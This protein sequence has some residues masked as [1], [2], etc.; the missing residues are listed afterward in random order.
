MSKS[1]AFSSQ[2]MTILSDRNFLLTKKVAL[3]KIMRL[4]GNLAQDLQQ[5]PIHQNFQ[6]PKGTDTKRGK[7]SKGENYKGLPYMVLDFPKLFN[8]KNIFTY[9]SMFWWGNSFSFTLHIG[10]DYALQY[11]ENILKN[12]KTLQQSEVF[13]CVN[14]TPW[15]YDFEAENYCNIADLDSIHVEEYI[16]ANG[17]I[18]LSRSLPLQDWERVTCYGSSTYQ[19][20]FNSLF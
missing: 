13:F 19:L 7:I 14:N 9:R 18:K 10:G 16:A 4:L 12:L 15:E 20:F 5:L 1:P 11:Q 2:E 17:F 8:K 3:T 6:F